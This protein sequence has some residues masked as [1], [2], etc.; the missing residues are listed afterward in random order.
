MAR[1]GAK[2]DKKQEQRIK[3]R[4]GEGAGGLQ[5]HQEGR[6]IQVGKLPSLGSTG[7]I[8]AGGGGGVET[9]S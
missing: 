4:G 6:R 2:G 1:Q 7:A 8:R 5:H 3:R 9:R